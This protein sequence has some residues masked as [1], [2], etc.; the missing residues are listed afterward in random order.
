MQRLLA[1][2]WLAIALLGPFLAQAEAAS[3]L[4]RTL[5]DVAETSNLEPLDEGVG[6]DPVV[7]AASK[8]APHMELCRLGHVSLDLVASSSISLPSFSGNVVRRPRG[9]EVCLPFT[10]RERI[11]WLKLLRI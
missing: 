9:L 7:A 10:A 6:D 1:L 8:V 5:A 11:A 2:F 3:D 4:A